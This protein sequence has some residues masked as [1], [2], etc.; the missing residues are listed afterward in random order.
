[1][2]LYDERLPPRFWRKVRTVTNGCWIWTASLDTA[3]YASFYWDGKVRAGHRVAY[4]ALVGPIPDGLDLDHVKARGCTST[5]CVNPAHLEPV[6]RLENSARGANPKYVAWR[7]NTCARGLHSLADVKVG[8]SGK[9]RCPVCR[10]DRERA[11]R[12]AR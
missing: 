3:G 9:R 2:L 4:Q 5:A 7:T 1:M 6:T 8:A 10:R 12:L 11:A